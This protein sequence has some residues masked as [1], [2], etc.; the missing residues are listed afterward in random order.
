ME[1]AAQFAAKA[2]ATLRLVHVV[3]AVEGWP[4]RQMDREFSEYVQEKARETIGRQMQVSK[5][6]AELCIAEGR[7]ADA[8]R[9]EALRH[10]ADLVI[11]GRGLLDETFGRLR[12]N[13]YGLIRSSPCPVLTV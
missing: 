12:T 2:K 3:S 7:I 8:I 6:Q 13:V 10:N 9:D 1:W 11:A 5:I 4:E